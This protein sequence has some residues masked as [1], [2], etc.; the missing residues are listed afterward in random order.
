[1]L[2]SLS[3]TSWKNLTNNPVWKTYLMVLSL[4]KFIWLV[5]VVE[6]FFMDWVFKQR[7]EG[8][9]D[10]FLLSIQIDYACQAFFVACSNIGVV[11][12]LAQRF[13]LIYP[14]ALEWRTLQMNSCER[15]SN[16][17]C[18]IYLDL[19]RVIKVPLVTALQKLANQTGFPNSFWL[20]L[21]KLNWF[22]LLLNLWV[23]LLD[24]NFL[25]CIVF[26]FIV[27]WGKA[28]AIVWGHWVSIW[29]WGRRW[30]GR[31]TRPNYLLRWK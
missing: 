10:S 12:F 19:L 4:V 6:A 30:G 8:F 18:R 1:M 7:R 29:I 13:G 9:W 3:V 17:L 26:D 28:W 15:L 31:E 22:L 5:R 16:L 21:S 27:W 11:G 25:V 20:L 24:A 2:L 14:W 23:D